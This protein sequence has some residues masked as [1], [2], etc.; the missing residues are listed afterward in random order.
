MVEAF[1]HLLTKLSAD[2]VIASYRGKRSDQLRDLIS[3][4]SSRD[5]ISVFLSRCFAMVNKSKQTSENEFVALPFSMTLK[6]SSTRMQR[7]V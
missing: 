5:E 4:W 2:R 6:S 1:Q 3:T 7:L